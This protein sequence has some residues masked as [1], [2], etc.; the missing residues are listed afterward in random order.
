M[1]VEKL[2]GRKTITNGKPLMIKRRIKTE[3]EINKM[4]IIGLLFVTAHKYLK[5]VKGNMKS[6]YFI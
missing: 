2:I 6:N 5:L 4:E 3:T 1:G